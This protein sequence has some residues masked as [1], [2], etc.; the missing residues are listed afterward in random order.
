MPSLF[1]LVDRVADIV[2]SV[3]HPRR[4]S[5]PPP[6]PAYSTPP[7]SP[8]RLGCHGRPEPDEPLSDYPQRPRA[9]PFAKIRRPQVPRANSHSENSRRYF[10]TSR[11]AKN[12]HWGHVTE[13]PS[14]SYLPGNS[15]IENYHSGEGRTMHYIYTSDD[16]T[17]NAGPGGSRKPS[18]KNAGSDSDSDSDSYEEK[19]YPHAAF[20]SPSKSTTWKGAPD[21]NS[22]P[23]R[24]IPL[25]RTLCPGK[26]ILKPPTATDNEMLIRN[27]WSMI[28]QSD[29]RLNYTYEFLSGVLLVGDEVLDTIFQISEFAMCEDATRNSPRQGASRGTR[30]GDRAMRP[31]TPSPPPDQSLRRSSPKQALSGFPKGESIQEEDEE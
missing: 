11:Q 13:V 27:L 30:A 29:Q 22:N 10:R 23:P 12:V 1:N 6:E 14:N 9:T 24:H 5:S 25:H 17:V 7:R 31:R 19:R 18:A 20:H 21:N 15:G 28:I 2:I 8:S 4:S 3:I 16:S 26:S